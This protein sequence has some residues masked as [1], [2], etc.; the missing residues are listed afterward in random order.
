MQ[1]IATHYKDDADVAVVTIQTTFEG[2]NI[3]DFAA[4]EEIAEKYALNIPM[5]HSGWPNKPSPLLYSYQ[6]RGTPWVVIVDRKGNIQF[7]NFYQKPAE[8]IRLINMLKEEK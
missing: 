2:F 7:S 8:S 5:G 3:N 4:L 6:A 1:E